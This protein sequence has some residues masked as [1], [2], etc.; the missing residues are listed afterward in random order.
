MEA[1]VWVGAQGERRS[2]DPRGLSHLGAGGG[3]LFPQGEGPGALDEG[4]EECGEN[5][6]GSGGRGGRLEPVCRLSFLLLR[7]RHHG[8]GAD[9]EVRGQRPCRGGCPG[10]RGPGLRA[11]WAGLAVPTWPPGALQVQQEQDSALQTHRTTALVGR[12]S[13]P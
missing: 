5:Q 11:S 6:G 3:R 9:R 13:S 1:Q 7:C 10:S 12:A 8:D 2:T 4:L